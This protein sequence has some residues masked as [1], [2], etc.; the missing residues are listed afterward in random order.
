[1]NPH[2]SELYFL[3]FLLLIILTLGFFLFKPFIYVLILAVV[4]ATV[5]NPLHLKILTWTGQRKTLAAL[6]STISVLIVVIIPI[7]FLA[8]Q[9]F[10]ETSGLYLSVTQ[11]DNSLD[12]NNKIERIVN[13]F[14]DFARLPTDFS[15]DVRQYTRQGL[16]W[17]ISHVAVIVSNF[18]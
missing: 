4:F 10:Q 3:L 12:F 5:F 9:V 18:A 11:G 15:I 6:L 14:K 2:K 7:S 1:M 13:N 16:E 17:V 8:T